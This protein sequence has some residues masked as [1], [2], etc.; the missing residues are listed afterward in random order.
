M[1][2]RLLGMLLTLVGIW[3]LYAAYRAFKS[4]RKRSNRLTTILTLFGLWTG[5]L[6]GV[7]V[8]ILG[9]GLLLGLI[10]AAQLSVLLMR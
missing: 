10:D 7:L 3:Q 1:W 2:L 6:F 8:L 5:L 9:M 4:F